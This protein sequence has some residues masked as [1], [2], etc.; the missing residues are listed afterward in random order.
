MHASGWITDRANQAFDAAVKHRHSAVVNLRKNRYRVE[1][2]F[3]GV[4]RRCCRFVDDPSSMMPKVV[5]PSTHCVQHGASAR[6][7]IKLG[8]SLRVQFRYDSVSKHPAC[9]EQM[10]VR[11]D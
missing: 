2:P 4:V 11:F 10:F 1:Q 6:V 9:S 3:K 7:E 8:G 5:I